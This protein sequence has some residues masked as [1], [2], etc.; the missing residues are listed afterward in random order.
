M[1]KRSPPPR[2][3]MQALFTLGSLLFLL[4]SAQL[5]ER[6]GYPEQQPPGLGSLTAWLV[7]WPEVLACW[8]L[9]LP[10]AL[11][12]ARARR[13]L[14]ACLPSTLERLESPAAAAACCHGEPCCKLCAPLL[15][16]LHCAAPS[17]RRAAINYPRLLPGALAC[18]GLRGKQY[19]PLLPA[20][21]LGEGRPAR[22]APRPTPAA[23]PGGLARGQ[24]VGGQPASGR[25]AGAWGALLGR[26]GLGRVKCGANAAGR[27]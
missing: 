17:G 13:L 19:G 6:I 16:C 4:A 22:P 20:A 26:L 8:L 15:R 2:L 1:R 23:T 11:L 27:C 18:P 12:Q 14:A 5:A 7:S 10:G 3:P 21:R 9:F 24:L 25:H